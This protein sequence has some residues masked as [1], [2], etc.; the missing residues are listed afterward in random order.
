MLLDCGRSYR[1]IMDAL[2]CRCDP[3]TLKRQFH[4]GVIQA[5]LTEPGVARV[6][7]FWKLAVI[8]WTPHS[9]PRDFGYLR[10]WW[11][12]GLFLRVLEEQLGVALG[13]EA[14]CLALHELEF[15]R[16]HLHPIAGLADPEVD[17]KMGPIK[18]PLEMLPEEEVAIFHDELGVH[19]NPKVG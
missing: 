18:R 12:C 10:S 4:A 6:I 9:T 13:C 1:E 19:S 2:F 8:G 15:A 5:V 11:N 16:R 3:V 14:V 7:P 17:A